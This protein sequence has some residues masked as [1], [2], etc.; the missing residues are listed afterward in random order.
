MR[1][2]VRNPQGVKEYLNIPASNRRELAQRIGGAWFTFNRNQYHVHQVVAESDSN[3]LTS[4]AIIGGIIGLLAG[5]F[6]ILVGGTLGGALG[7][8]GDKTENE[9]VN[10]FNRSTV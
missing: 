10:Y 1:I 3:N 5:P 9:K 7:N 8:E 6:G 2:F 4:G